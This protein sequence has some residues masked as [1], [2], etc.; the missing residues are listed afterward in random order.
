MVYLYPRPL[1]YLILALIAL[2]IF[3][4]VRLRD[5]RLGRAWVAI[6]EDKVRR[7]LRY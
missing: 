3:A 7:H 2:T 5:S 1:L 4:N 6:R